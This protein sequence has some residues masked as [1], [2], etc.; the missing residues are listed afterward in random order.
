M[1]WFWQRM[2]END[3]DKMFKQKKE[4]ELQ[5]LIEKIDTGTEVEYLGQRMTIIWWYYDGGY[6]RGGTYISEIMIV[7]QWFDKL[8]RIQTGEITPRERT[9]MRILS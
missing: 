3:E 1:K 8:G 4:Q 2:E 7:T 5:E 9:L 6:R